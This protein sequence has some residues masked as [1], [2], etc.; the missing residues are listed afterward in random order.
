MVNQLCLHGMHIHRAVSVISATAVIEITSRRTRRS[1]FLSDSAPRCQYRPWMTSTGRGDPS[2]ATMSQSIISNS[3]RSGRS[4]DE[5]GVNPGQMWSRYTYKG[6]QKVSWPSDNFGV[7]RGSNRAFLWGTDN[8]LW[9]GNRAF[10]W[11]TRLAL[12][13]MASIW[14]FI[15]IPGPHLTRNYPSRTLPWTWVLPHVSEP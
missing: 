13:P 8:K 9:V 15:C 1:S 4:R 3:G 7:S 6:P 11:S 14:N 12:P 2:L 10:M 5:L